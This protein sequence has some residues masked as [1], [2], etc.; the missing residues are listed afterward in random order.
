HRRA[1]AAPR[2]PRPAGPPGDRNARSL[3]RSVVLVRP[4]ACRFLAVAC[5]SALPVSSSLLDPGG[6]VGMPHDGRRDAGAFV[7]EARFDGC[8]A[9]ASWRRVEVAALL[10]PELELAPG[11]RGVDDTHPVLLSS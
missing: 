8:V 5:Y 1:W 7:G 4:S 2:P 9:V 11:A 6:V 3:R 10:P